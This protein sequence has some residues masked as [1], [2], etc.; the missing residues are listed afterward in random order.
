MGGGGGTN[1][2]LP[3]NKKSGGGGHMPP[4]PPPPPRF[5]RQC[6]YIY[7]YIYIHT[8]LFFVCE[9]GIFALQSRPSIV[10]LRNGRELPSCSSQRVY[11]VVLSG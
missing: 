5:L 8:H 10:N 9:M 4:L 3:P 6:M 11:D 2:P 7:I 1:I